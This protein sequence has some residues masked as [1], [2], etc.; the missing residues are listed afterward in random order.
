RFTD[1]AG[2]FRVKRYVAA[3]Q[4]RPDD[5]GGADTFAVARGKIVALKFQARYF[6]KHIGFGKLLGADHYFI[7]GRHRTMQTADEKQQDRNEQGAF[8]HYRSTRLRWA[9][10]NSETKGSA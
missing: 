5:A 4:R 2:V 8:C 1:G 6:A 7:C 3:H 10:R 9:C